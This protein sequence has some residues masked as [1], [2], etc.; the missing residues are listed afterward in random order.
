MMKA[1]AKLMTRTMDGCLILNE[2]GRTRVKL[3]QRV[4]PQ[5][6]CA[7]LSPNITW[8]KGNDSLRITRYE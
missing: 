1:G 7:P 5:P 3:C 8:A 2:L 4:L 6:N